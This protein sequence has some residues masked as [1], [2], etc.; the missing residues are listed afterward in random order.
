MIVRAPRDPFLQMIDNG[1]ETTYP[2][3]ESNYI[4][5]FDQW[6]ELRAKI[7]AFYE[8]I[9]IAEV[10]RYNDDVRRAKDERDRLYQKQQDRQPLPGYVYL[11]KAIDT[12]WF[13]V[14]QSLKPKIRAKQLGTR[15][16]YDIAI[17]K[18]HAVSDMD[19]AEAYWH[20]RFTNKRGNGEWFTLD[21][22][23]VRSFCLWQPDQ[24][25]DL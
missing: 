2:L 20:Q 17:I 21:P 16:P 15:S 3:S 19:R 7:D 14:G 25:S 24:G 6:Q 13:K 11:I 1:D 18:T 4:L 5:T 22:D 12:P 9:E 10:E 23:D 8:N